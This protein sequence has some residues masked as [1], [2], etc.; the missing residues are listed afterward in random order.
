MRRLLLLILIV[1]LIVH[2]GCARK[3][4]KAKGLS[5]EDEMAVLNPTRPLVPETTRPDTPQ[6]TKSDETKPDVKPPATKPTPTV[7]ATEKQP[8][9]AEVVEKAAKDIEGLKGRVFKDLKSKDKPVISIDLYTCTEPDKALAMVKVFPKLRELSLYKNAMITDASLDHIKGLTALNELNLNFTK[10][11]DKGVENLKGLTQLKELHLSGTEIGDPGVAL[12]KDLTQ[13]EV[14]DLS[15]TKATG[16]ALE[17]LKG[18][19][20]LAKLELAGVKLEDGQ[21]EELMK[22][23]PKLKVTK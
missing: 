23:L 5:T 21:L 4:P 19:A 20:K 18:M 11:T 16:A 9:P 3:K 22:I 17:N 15:R 13:L 8:E 14:L 6:P 12:L 1:P 10:I 2:G 7:K